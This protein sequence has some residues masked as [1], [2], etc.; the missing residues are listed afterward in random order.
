M[1]FN[2]LDGG[3]GWAPPPQAGDLVKDALKREQ[4]LKSALLLR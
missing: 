1:S 2:D 4:L 3:G